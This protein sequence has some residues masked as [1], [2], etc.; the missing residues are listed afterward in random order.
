MK[1]VVWAAVA[2]LAVGLLFF[3][4]PIVYSPYHVVTCGGPQPPSGQAPGC[5]DFLVSAYDSPSCLLLRVGVA[6]DNFT[7]GY[8]TTASG[9]TLDTKGAWSYYLGCAPDET[10]YFYFY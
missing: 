3:L 2:V 6:G 8:H 7:S 5:K 4:A 1:R 9:F 10:L